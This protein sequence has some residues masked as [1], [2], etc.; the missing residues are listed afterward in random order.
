[1]GRHTGLQRRIHAA[2]HDDCH[3]QLKACDV[4]CH[5]LSGIRIETNAID[6]DATPTIGRTDPGGI[7][8]EHHDLARV[9][10]GGGFDGHRDDDMS[11]TKV[12]T[13]CSARNLCAGW[14]VST[15]TG[16]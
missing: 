1:M 16:K 2:T 3:S 15:M 11:D 12:S 14:A 10:L 5:R 9:R 8:A 4:L 6:D 7:G 13:A